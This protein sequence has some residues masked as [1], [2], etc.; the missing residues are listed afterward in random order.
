[1]LDPRIYRT[2]LVPVVLAVI[3]LAFSLQNQP[4]ALSTTLAPD[5]YS[6]QN[7]YATMNALAARYPDRRPGS[8]G[9]RGVADYVA[10]ALGRDNFTVSRDS[11]SGHT[12]D[13]TTA[14]QNVTG[15]RAGQLAG[16]I[17]IVSARDSLRGPA[18]AQLSGTAVMLELARLL[19]GETQQHT[20]VLASISGTAGGAGA[21]RLADTLPQPVDAV[22]VLGDLAGT[23]VHQPLVV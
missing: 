10:A 15:M 3:V 20:V 5:A 6:A 22:I 13:G 4:G 21:L 8:A 16:T 19:A 11:F 12:V 2:G 17:A 1:M 14:L 23:T 9:D 7:A 18:R